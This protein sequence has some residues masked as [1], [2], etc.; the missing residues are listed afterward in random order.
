[1]I[2]LGCAVALSTD[3]NPGSCYTQ[4]M[5]LIITLGCILLRMSVEECITAT[6]INPAA[7][8]HLDEEVGSLHPGKRADFAVLDLPS[9]RALG[10]AFGGNPVALTI[11][12]GSPVVANI[13]DRDPDLFAATG[14]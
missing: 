2:D 6:T 5:P 3:F 12:D 14:D 7:S 11:K 9:H 1:M 13:R 8:L 10:Y 4:S